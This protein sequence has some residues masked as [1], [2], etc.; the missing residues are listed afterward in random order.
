MIVAFNALMEIGF[1]KKLSMSPQ[2]FKSIYT[3]TR[4]ELYK[5]SLWKKGVDYEHINIM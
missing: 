2:W 5:H 3:N 1:I 4:H